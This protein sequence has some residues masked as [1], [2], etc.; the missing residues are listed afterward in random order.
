[1][2][3]EAD[4]CEDFYRFACGG[5]MVGNKIIIIIIIII[6]KTIIRVWY[7]CQDSNV[8]PDGMSKWGAFYELRDQVNNALKS[9]NLNHFRFRSKKNLSSTHPAIVTDPNESSSKAV[10]NLKAM[11]NGC[12][13]TQTIEVSLIV[14]VL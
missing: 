9:E 3:V 10:T 13:D 11:Y 14:L 5:W 8:I 6:I 12:M 4:P 2:D 7:V 1:M